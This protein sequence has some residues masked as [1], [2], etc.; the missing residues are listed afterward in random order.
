MLKHWNNAPGSCC[1]CKVHVTYLQTVY[2]RRWFY[3]FLLVSPGAQAWS[4]GY[5]FNISESRAGKSLARKRCEFE[6]TRFDQGRSILHDLSSLLTVQYYFNLHMLDLTGYVD[7]SQV[8]V[9]RHFLMA[10]SIG[11]ELSY[12]LALFNILFDTGVI[13]SPVCICVAGEWSV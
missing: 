11:N 12:S 1:N 13:I 3:H 10:I 7:Y 9:L 4:L 2:C 6:S 5:L 8:L